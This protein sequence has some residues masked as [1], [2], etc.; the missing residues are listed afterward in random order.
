MKS[1]K[2]NKL[3]LIF[4]IGILH[5]D[6]SQHSNFF[7]VYWQLKRPSIPRYKCYPL[8]QTSLP[9]HLQITADKIKREKNDYIVGETFSSLFA[10]HFNYFGD[11]N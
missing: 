10:I 3:W 4:Q 7:H 1:H 9:F 11:S 5:F 6:C 8:S 2:R